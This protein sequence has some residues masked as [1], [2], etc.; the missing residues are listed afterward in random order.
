M[1]GAV[2]VEGGFPLKKICFWGSGLLVACAKMLSTIPPPPPLINPFLGAGG[3]HPRGNRFLYPFDEQ[4]DAA[5]C[6]SIVTT[7][8]A[9]GWLVQFL[10]RGGSTPYFLF[11]LAL[12]CLWPVP[13][14]LATIP[15]PHL[16]L[17]FTFWRLLD[18][19]P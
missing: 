8:S 3:G 13:K 5:Q 15:P 6:F 10:W 11:L 18:V 16:P 9:F 14:M 19:P 4:L 2:L 17:L 12:A 1:V 7:S